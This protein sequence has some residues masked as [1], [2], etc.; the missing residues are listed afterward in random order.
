MG[1]IKVNNPSKSKVEEWTNFVFLFCNEISV[2][3]FGLLKNNFKKKL[4]TKSSYL[5]FF[6]TCTS[7][8]S[9]SF[10]IDFKTYVSRFVSLKTVTI[11]LQS[12]NY[13]TF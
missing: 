4:V 8:F 6:L 12:F 1:V 13:K 10:S 5:H 3:F 7:K 9:A 11:K 2:S